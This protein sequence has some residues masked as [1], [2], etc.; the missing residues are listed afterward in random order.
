MTDLLSRRAFL[1]S[2]A[3]GVAVTRAGDIP[4]PM[5]PPRPLPPRSRWAAKPVAVSSAN[6]LRAVQ[7]AFD[8]LLQG[9][10]TLDAVIEG[11]KAS[12]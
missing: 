5:R 8:M 11:V 12:L 2:A 6:G 4:F 7:K 3:V 10:D 1:A 9:A